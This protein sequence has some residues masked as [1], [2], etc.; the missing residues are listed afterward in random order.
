MYGAA[1]ADS[2]ILIQAEA[3]LTGLPGRL[4]ALIPAT[5]GVTHV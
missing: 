5:E 1:A 2:I 4:V 3:R